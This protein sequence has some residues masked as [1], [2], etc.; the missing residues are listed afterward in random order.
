MSDP[1]YL[2]IFRNA[3]AHLAE[4][5]AYDALYRTSPNRTTKDAAT[6]SYVRV[7]EALVKDL[8]Q[9][10]ELGILDLIEVN[11]AGDAAH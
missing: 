2:Q 6:E 4:A 3:R 1:D 7:V 8:T 9:L 11:L 5:Q 10:E